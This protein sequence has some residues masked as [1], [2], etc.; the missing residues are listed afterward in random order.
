MIKLLYC[1]WL[2]PTNHRPKGIVTFQLWFS[3][4]LYL[5]TV[6]LP[7]MV[8][9]LLFFAFK[10]QID[11]IVQLGRMVTPKPRTNFYN[12]PPAVTPKPNPPSP[13]RPY[14]H[15][16]PTPTPSYT[17]TQ[18]PPNPVKPPS[19]SFLGFIPTSLPYHPTTS[20]S[21]NGGWWPVGGM[22]TNYFYACKRSNMCNK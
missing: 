10:A 14:T 17:Y 8:I 19:S 1:L 9:Y 16:P 3:R 7:M 15:R 13:H 20:E 22:W 5:N 2:L 6:C 18:Q 11:R 21:V 4:V 12:P